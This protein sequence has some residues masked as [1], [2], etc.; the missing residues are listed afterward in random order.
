MML[1][2]RRREPAAQGEKK[3]ANRDAAAWPRYI[4]EPQR[5]G[6]ESADLQEDMI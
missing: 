6:G 1:V 2:D 3:A 5:P 4:V